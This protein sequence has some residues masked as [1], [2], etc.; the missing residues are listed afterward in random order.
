MSAESDSEREKIMADFE[1]SSH[2]PA[3]RAFTRPIYLYPAFAKY[4][5]TGDPN[6]AENFVPAN[7]N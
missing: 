5:G 1:K 3:N 2:D 6:K 4:K 7:D